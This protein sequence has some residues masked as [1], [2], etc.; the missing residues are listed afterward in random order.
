MCVYLYSHGVR[1][2]LL[3]SDGMPATYQQK[4]HP[5]STQAGIDLG[6][7]QANVGSNAPT[8]PLAKPRTSDTG[9]LVTLRNSSWPRSGEAP[10]SDPLASHSLAMHLSSHCE[11]TLGSQPTLTKRSNLHY[12]PTKK[13]TSYDQV[14][15]RRVCESVHKVPS[16]VQKTI[17]RFPV[18]LGLGHLPYMNHTQSHWTQFFSKKKLTR[19][20]GELTAVAIQEHLDGVIHERRDANETHFAPRWQSRSSNWRTSSTRLA[21]SPRS[22]ACQ[23]ITGMN[24]S[25]KSKA[26]WNHV[27]DGS[28][29]AQT[30]ALSH[31]DSGREAPWVNDRH[32]KMRQ[33]KCEEYMWNCKLYT[34]PHKTKW[35]GC[36]VFGFVIFEHVWD[37]VVKRFEVL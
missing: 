25:T 32:A 24:A 21:E 36:A 33:R 35:R 20:H 7:A 29:K 2:P 8:K 10:F 22:R 14:C 26:S 11:Y 16:K 6:F 18:L 23:P 30:R 31:S 19:R 34:R 12:H 17:Q 4:Q 15:H 9:T 37:V 27:K 28:E 13:T 3:V 1:V 5:R